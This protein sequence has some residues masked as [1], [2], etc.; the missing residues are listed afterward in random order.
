MV[1]FPQVPHQN[2][3][4]TSFLPHTRYMSHPS[5]SSRFN[6]P[7][8]IGEEYRSLS[9]TFCS[10]LHY[11]VNSSLLGPNC[12]LNTLSLRSSLN[13]RGQVSHSQNYGSLNF[14]IAD[15]K[16]KTLIS[17]TVLKTTWLVPVCINHSNPLHLPLRCFLQVWFEYYFPNSVVFICQVYPEKPSIRSS[18][19]WEFT[20][21]DW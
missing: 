10:F 20:L 12:L 13:V 16:T 14:W 17:N 6:H 3:V 4:Y 15:W 8:N 2:P 5:H 21:Q 9:S 19:F 18:L 11:P 7:N 1:S